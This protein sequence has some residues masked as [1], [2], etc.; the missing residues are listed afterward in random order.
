MMVMLH[1]IAYKINSSFSGVLGLPTFKIFY[2]YNVISDRNSNLNSC[3]NSSF[4]Y[5][6]LNHYNNSNWINP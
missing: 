2:I 3:N 4:I 6:Y 1:K 5:S